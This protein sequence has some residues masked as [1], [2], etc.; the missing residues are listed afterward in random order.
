MPDETTD[1]LMIR[2]A[3]NKTLTGADI[4]QKGLHATLIP[5]DRGLAIKSVKGRESDFS[6]L[7]ARASGKD[8]GAGAWVAMSNA[9]NWKDLKQ[10]VPLGSTLIVAWVKEA[11]LTPPHDATLLLNE[12]P[13]T[14]AGGSATTSVGDAVTSEEVGKYASGS[15]YTPIACIN[16]V[17]YG[18]IARLVIGGDDVSYRQD[19]TP[20]GGQ[21]TPNNYIRTLDGV[22]HG[23]SSLDSYY[24]FVSF[25]PIDANRSLIPLAEAAQSCRTTVDPDG[26]TRVHIPITKDLAPDLHGRLCFVSPLTPRKMWNGRWVNQSNANVLD[27]FWYQQDPGGERMVCEHKRLKLEVRF[28]PEKP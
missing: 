21:R 6:A 2:P 8:A 14:T 11:D 10:E 5:R 26:R 16:N 19:V 13:T 9:P 18:D 15:P 1:E 28:A 12:E 7:D 23:R 22:I 20:P 25:D 4:L 17:R 24:L 27:R 3:G